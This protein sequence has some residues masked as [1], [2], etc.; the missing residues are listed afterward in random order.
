[1]D[2]QA[3]D[4]V[5]RVYEAASQPDAWDPLLEDLAGRMRGSVPALFLIDAGSGET[6][7]ERAPAL[8]P[9]W[10]RAYA[11][12]YHRLDLRR[13]ALNQRPE[14]TVIAGHALLSEEVLLRSEFYNEF[15]R[16]QGFFHIALAQP[17]RRP[18]RVA[19]IRVIRALGEEPFDDAD[20]VSLRTL[21][22]HLRAALDLHCE[23]REARRLAAGLSGALAV[24]GVGAILLDA[25]GR[26]AF[27]NAEAERLLA[28]G[29]GL[30]VRRGRLRLDAPSEDAALQRLAASRSG[31]GALKI[32]RPSGRSTLEARVIP[33]PAGGGE[34]GA[35][36]ASTLVFLREPERACALDPETLRALYGLTPAELRVATLV[37]EGSSAPAV[38]RALGVSVETVRTHQKRLGE[39]TGARGR[40]QLVRLLSG[41]LAS[42]REPR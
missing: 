23:L 33:L 32:T 8:D 12:H 27:A 2:P 17:I 22:P 29:D 41:S 20:L 25:G 14:G 3:L 16:P 13:R 5:P 35:P 18:G 34:L 26:V 21:V 31:G 7:L 37:A 4:L 40:G 10:Q 28:A 11:D 19:A 9:A 42:L 39:K 30:A 6:L 36:T 15:L 38:A 1:V 24:L